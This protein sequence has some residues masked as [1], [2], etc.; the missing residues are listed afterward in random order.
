MITTA[1]PACNILL[2]VEMNI[3]SHMGMAY[4]EN[5]AQGMPSHP[6][7]SLLISVVLQA[8]DTC[9]LKM[10]PKSTGQLT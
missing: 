5:N 1:A 2:I 6:G 8:R 7:F 3:A 9:I 10:S 4:V